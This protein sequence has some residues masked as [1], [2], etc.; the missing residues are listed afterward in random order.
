MLSWNSQGLGNPWTVR[1]LHKIVKE[2]A[3]DI[4]FLMETRL[5]IEG[6]KYWCRELSYKNKF[7][8]KKPVGGGGLAMLWKEDIR[9]DVFKF[10][11][12]QISA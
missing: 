5:D 12:N 10:S 9:L 2:Q 8:V 11:E 4:C 7:A 1:S 6:I 3:P